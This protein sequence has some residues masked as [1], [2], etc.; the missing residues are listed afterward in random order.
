MLA[1]LPARSVHAVL[2]DPTYGSTDCAWDHCV[3]LPAWW[4]QIDR[5][6]TETSVVACFV[7][8]PFA[9]DLINGRRKTFRYE[10]VWDKLAPVGFLNANR[11]PMRVHELLLIFCRRPGKAVYNPQF[12]VGKPYKMKAKADRC[13]VYR[14]HR[15]IAIDNPGRR[16]PTSILRHAKP[17]GKHRR[18]PTEKPASLLS[19]MVLSY[20]RSG[21][22]VLDPFMGSAS[23]GEAALMHDRRFIGIEKDRDIFQGAAARLRPLM[24]PADR[25]VLRASFE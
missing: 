8:Q 7:A 1:S 17:V 2:T 24:S 21:T 20:T 6:T 5:V 16:H 12:T 11:Q 9:T 4:D 10:L 3:D 15:P 13:S 14:R 19:W 18:H 25:G 23:T 22:T